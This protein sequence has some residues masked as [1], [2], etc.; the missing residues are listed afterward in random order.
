MLPRLLSC[1]RA[2]SSF[3]LCGIVK[4]N[5]QNT[6]QTGFTQWA[7]R[8]VDHLSSGNRWHSFNQRQKLVVGSLECRCI[9]GFLKKDHEL[10]HC[11]ARSLWDTKTGRFRPELDCIQDRVE[12]ARG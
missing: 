10:D 6:I 7:A 8:D 9:D 12:I 2:Q 3:H 1:K 5:F 11:Q 4:I